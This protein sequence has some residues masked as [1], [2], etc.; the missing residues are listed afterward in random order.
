MAKPKLKIYIRPGQAASEEAIE[1][2]D[3]QEIDYD[4]IDVLDEETALDYL[5]EMTGERATPAV[6]FGEHTLS[7]FNLDELE[8]FLLAEKLIAPE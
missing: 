6:I 8:E 5:E 4:V 7:G 1:F 2:L 3:E